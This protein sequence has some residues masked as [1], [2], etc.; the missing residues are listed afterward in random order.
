MA[1]PSVNEKEAR[2]KGWA[3]S[4]VRS[5]PDH[6]GLPS[7]AAAIHTVGLVWLRAPLSNFR[8]RLFERVIVSR[9]AL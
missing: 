1:A 4:H 8:H 6:S 9:F 7:I 3:L 2:S 5:V